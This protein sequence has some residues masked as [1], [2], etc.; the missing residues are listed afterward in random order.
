MDTLTAIFSWFGICLIP[1]GFYFILG[2]LAEIYDY[3]IR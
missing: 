1:L 2:I 3:F